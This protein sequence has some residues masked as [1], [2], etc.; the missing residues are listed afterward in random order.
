MREVGVPGGKAWKGHAGG[1]GCRAGG[2]GVAGTSDS[3]AVRASPCVGGTEMRWGRDLPKATCC[4]HG[5]RGLGLGAPAS[6]TLS[7]SFLNLLR[8]RDVRLFV[9]D[10]GLKAQPA[11]TVCERPASAP[12]LDRSHLSPSLS[13]QRAKS[14]CSPP[15]LGGLGL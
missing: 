11:G 4:F 15:A 7:I 3:W 12:A 1:P 5:E 2:G 8:D 9:G 14:A 6:P 13:F 10:L